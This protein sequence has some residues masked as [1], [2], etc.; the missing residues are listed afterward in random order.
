[1]LS[2]SAIVIAHVQRDTE[3][4]NALN[5]LPDALRVAGQ[6]DWTKAVDELRDV[7]RMI[8]I[9]RGTGLASRRKRR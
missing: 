6:L 9:G 3:L 7:D 4:L 1:M 5:T 8:V 2:L